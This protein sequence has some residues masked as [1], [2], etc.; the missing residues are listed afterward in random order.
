MFGSMIARKFGVATAQ[1]LLGH[2]DLQT[3]ARYLAAE[4]VDSAAQKSVD[5]LFDGVGRQDDMHLH[6]T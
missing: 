1:R 4:E 2:A 3:T 5:D 6:R